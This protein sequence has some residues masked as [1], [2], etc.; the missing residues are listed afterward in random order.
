MVLIQLQRKFSSFDL[1]SDCNST[2]GVVITGCHA[3]KVKFG[4][5]DFNLKIL[6][7]SKNSEK[8]VRL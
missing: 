4:F 3:L 1:S 8:K 2:E 5:Q 7:K 6:T